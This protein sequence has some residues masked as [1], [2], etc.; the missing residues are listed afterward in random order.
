M[1]ESKF[2]FSNTQPQVE[3]RGLPVESTGK[4]YMQKL[5]LIPGYLQY[6]H[7]AVPS[8]FTRTVLT[9]FHG[10]WKNSH[11]FSAQWQG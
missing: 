5:Y 3:G 9:V 2:T 8:K 7:A 10:P 11:E 1:N 6:L 4:H